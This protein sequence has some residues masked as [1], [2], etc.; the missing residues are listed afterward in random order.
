[1]VLAILHMCLFRGHDV[2][3]VSFTL[4]PAGLSVALRVIVYFS[5]RNANG[6]KT[7]T[8]LDADYRGFGPIF[9]LT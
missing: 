2:I 4:R 3:V 7:N 8:M 5:V 1:M 6:I 9:V